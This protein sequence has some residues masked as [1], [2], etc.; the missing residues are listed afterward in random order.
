MVTVVDEGGRPIPGSTMRVG[1]RTHTGKDGVIVVAGDQ[2]LAGVIAADGYLSEPLVVSRNLA[3][4]FRVRLWAERGPSGAARI[5]LHAAGDV[6]LGRRYLRPLR[7]DT[8]MVVPGDGGKSARSVVSSIGQIF[9]AADISSVNLET[10]VGDITSAGSYPGKRFLLRSPPETVE[11]LT[12]LG[13]D[14]VTLGNN[15]ANDWENAGVAS[16]RGELTRAGMPFTGAGSRDAEAR[17]PAVLERRGLSLATLSYTTVTGDVV[18]DHLPTSNASRPADLRAKDAWQYDFRTLA[19]GAPGD[20]VH[21]APGRYRAGDAWAAFSAPSNLEPATDA[22]VWRELRTV[23]PELQDWVARRDHG[24]AARF[25]A[26]K[27]TEDVKAARANGAELVVVQ[28]HGGFQFSDVASTFLREAAHASVRAGADIVIGHHPHVIQG[29]EWYRGKLIVHSLGNFVFDQDFWQTFPSMFVRAVFE[30]DHL[31]EARVYPLVLE[32]YRP[33]AVSGASAA[34]IL[35]EVRADSSLFAPAARTPSGAVS[36]SP[37]RGER[38][39][40]RRS[41]CSAGARRDG[42]RDRI[43]FRSRISSGRRRRPPRWNGGGN[44]PSALRRVR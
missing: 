34:H 26:R 7:S 42:G 4:D 35:Q 27:V 29:L 8:P 16:T 2:P 24:G 32:R 15:H 28:I 44:R 36:R 43:R 9:G 10:V 21:L 11:A 17:A 20:A 18:N 31:L 39:R 30:G 22:R 3:P 6:M 19:V 33:V 5:S 23:F 38:R 1:A 37:D 25:S 13:V 14:V 40:G 41:A 12:K